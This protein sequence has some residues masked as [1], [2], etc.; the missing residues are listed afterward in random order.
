MAGMIILK[1]SGIKPKEKRKYPYRELKVGDSF[2]VPGKK[3]NQCSF[4]QQNENEW[5][6][7]AGKPLVKFTLSQ[8]YA[9]YQNKAWHPTDNPTATKGVWVTRIQ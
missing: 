4:M 3:S 5:R 9:I 8:S 6:E 1:D 2:F 7:R